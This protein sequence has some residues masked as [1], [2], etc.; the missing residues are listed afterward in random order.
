VTDFSGGGFNFGD[1]VS[2]IGSLVGGFLNAGV[3]DA[4][5]KGFETASANF[6]SMAALEQQVT[7]VKQA[8][9]TRTA[10]LTYGTTAADI[11]GA[12]F[13]APVAGTDPNHPVAGWG[14][15]RGTLGVGGGGGVGFARG[16]GRP[17][18]A[19]AVGA[20]GTFSPLIMEAHAQGGLTPALIGMQGGLQQLQYEEEASAAQAQAAAAKAQGTADIVG[21]IFGAVGKIG[22]MFL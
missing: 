19:N 10:Q 8:M 6:Q 17:A 2:G 1:A 5:A 22:G 13:E 3:A 20:P 9:A 16:P 18:N 4:E 15:K 12:G 11:G 21:G 7:G 14:G